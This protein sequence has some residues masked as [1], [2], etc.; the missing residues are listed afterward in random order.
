LERIER[1]LDRRLAQASRC[2]NA[3]AEPDDARKGIDHAKAVADRARH[4]QTA[5]IG[6]EI[7][8]G[9]S[10]PAPVI[11]GACLASSRRPPTPPGLAE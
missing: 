8:R 4:Q 2:R 6:A 3:L 11:A 7:E 5:I 10:R 1:A 9:I